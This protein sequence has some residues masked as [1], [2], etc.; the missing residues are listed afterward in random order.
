MTIL[1][2][3]GPFLLHRLFWQ[4]N[5]ILSFPNIEIGYFI[6]FLLLAF[7]LVI[8]R[9]RLEPKT[10][11][12]RQQ[13]ALSRERKFITPFIDSPSDGKVSNEHRD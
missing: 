5:N 12:S 11:G 1:V 7:V 9:R 3:A 8:L 13:K 4:L 2:M 10:N 6:A